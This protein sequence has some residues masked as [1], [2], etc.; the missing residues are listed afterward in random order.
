[1]STF[2]LLLVIG[3]VII[4]IRLYSATYYVDGENQNASDA[5]TGTE[6]QPWATIGKA[7]STL[8]AGDTVY[9]KQGTYSITSAITPANS[10]NANAYIIYSSW[11]DNTGEVV[12]DGTDCPLLYSGNV[13]YGLMRIL[14]KSYIKI[15]GLKFVNS[16]Y[17]GIW[18]NG[19]NI[20]I[21]G[22]KT[23]QT[24]S[25]GVQ[26]WGGLNTIVDG[27]EIERG[28]WDYRTNG[29]SG[30]IHECISI[31]A[32][33]H[34]DVLNN[35]VYDSGYTTSGYGKEGIDIKN[36]CTN[37][38][39]Y[40]NYVHDT[41]SI[42]IYLDARGDEE[43]IDI[44]NNTISDCDSDGIVVATENDAGTLKNIRVFNNLI[45]NNTR[46]GI[47]IGWANDYPLET[48]SVFNNTVCNNQYGII[49]HSL[50]ADDVVIKSN[51]LSNNS[52]YQLHKTT[53]I[54]FTCDNNLV[55]GTTT[56]TGDNAVTSA[57]LFANPD[58]GDFDLLSN[59]P[60]IDSGSNLTQTTATGT[61]SYVVPVIRAAYFMTG[62]I[63]YYDNSI[64]VGQN[65][66][67]KIVSVDYDN[68]TITVDSSISWNSGDSVNYAWSGSTPDLGRE[69]KL[70]GYWK[71]DQN[72]SD[73][74]PNNNSGTSYGN[75][76]WNS[77][78]MVSDSLVLDGT[79]DYVDFGN[80]A[81]LSP[82]TN[83]FSITFW[84]KP[85]SLPE[86]FSGI[87]FKGN[88]NVSDQDGWILR[89]RFGK[90]QFHMGD[91]VNN[92]GG[93][94]IDYILPL[95]EWT[96]VT[97][98]VK[99]S[100]GYLGYINGKYV[101]GYT[102]DTSN[103]DVNGTNLRI[104]RDWSTS[105][106]FFDGEIDEVKIYRK[107][108]SENDIKN[109]YCTKYDI[110][111]HWGL[112]S[113]A[114]DE[115]PYS[116]TGTTY[117]NPT[118]NT[119]GVIDGSIDLDG[120]DDYVY[121]GNSDILKPQYR[122]FTVECWL[123]PNALPT[124]YAGIVFKGNGNMNTQDGWFLRYYAN[125]GKVYFHMGDGTNNLG[126]MWVDYV[127]PLNEWTHVVVV[128]DRNDGYF[129]Y[130]NGTLVGN[131]TIDTSGN[132]VNGTS[133]YIGRDWSTSDYFFDGEIDEVKV[134]R[135]AL[136]SYEVLNQY[137]DQ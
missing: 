75:P 87:I 83:D 11:P 31:L 110:V 90:I 63:D 134:Y 48:I 101:N 99:R 42:G 88:G 86:D 25:S 121:C 127:L 6:A 45:Y 52:D 124:S 26:V 94:Y 112:N 93:F 21:K 72:T 92:L 36:A 97:V 19:D 70:C 125:T 91:G 14:G 8:T 81:S 16:R 7:A 34:V 46:R 54:T 118:W 104:G 123:K 17:A 126:G 102:I 137:N 37:V 61:N 66:P 132:E 4:G 27:N 129:A 10:G 135:K 77:N 62:S 122:D 22:N 82:G 114:N 67:V 120:T 49:L 117:G 85:D 130:A 111:G 29:L 95:G 119:S 98:V 89:Y 15:L 33:N 69:C 116:N 23:Y 51:I 84:V 12:I 2:R 50:D 1:M 58:Y 76:T 106:Y 5:N 13:Y 113:N 80:D 64:K 41:T 55:Y 128:V 68:N 28:C 131:Y 39:V 105:N 24:A 44:F 47:G 35:H 115:S 74:T 78:G 3:L 73:E 65:D 32:S 96:N 20:I 30:G 9:I 43:N 56:F 100:E 60:A 136:S 38:R 79:D 18:T 53:Q 40:N 133:L 107:A 71:L 108:L 109:K 103:N 59:S 57:P